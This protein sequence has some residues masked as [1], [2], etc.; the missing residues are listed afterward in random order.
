MR[1]V[2]YGRHQVGM[3]VLLYLLSEGYT[4]KVLTPEDELIENIA[5]NAA[6]EIVTLDTMGTFDL[7]ICVHGSKIIPAQYLVEGK[8]IN[9]HP[10]FRKYK[11]SNPI[12]RY[13]SHDDTLGSVTAHFMT[14]KV[15]KGEEIF[16]VFFNTPLLEFREQ[17]Y[18]HALRYYI[19]CIQQALKIFRVNIKEL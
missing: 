7:F 2:F 12:K 9:M 18:M 8:F 13:I 3:V 14:E 5:K 4:V 17:F 10:C 15:D 16:T 19:E 11:G 6:L 1:I